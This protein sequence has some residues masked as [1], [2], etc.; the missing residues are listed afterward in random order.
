MKIGLDDAKALYKE[1]L[2][3]TKNYLMD[4]KGFDKI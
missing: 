4:Y 3:N 2:E 1:M